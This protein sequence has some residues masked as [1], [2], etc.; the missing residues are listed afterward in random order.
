MRVILTS[1]ALVALLSPAQAKWFGDKDPRLDPSALVTDSERDFYSAIVRVFCP[2]SK[3]GLPS[4]TYYST[5]FHVGAFDIVVTNAHAFSESKPNAKTGKSEL[6]KVPFDRCK[7]EVL[8][9]KGY[10]LEEVAIQSV[11]SRWD[12]PD[13][14]SDRSND[15]AIIKLQHETKYPK[16]ALPYR[17][18]FDQG[19]PPIAA[20]E[21]IDVVVVG[22]P[23]EIDCCTLRKS[24]GFVE[25]APVK[26]PHREG[27]Y[28]DGEP[29]R[30]S[31]YFV[32]GNYA[33][34]KGASGSP[35]LSNGKVIGIHQGNFDGILP[36]GSK[37][38]VYNP[39]RNYNTA[40]LFDERFYRDIQAAKK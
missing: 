11:N 6:V 37:D 5:G 13:S 10:P 21:R 36:D 28:K 40:I 30:N 38:R 34:S 4:K 16:T 15:I 35:L 33:A 12:D 25:R 1:I 29:F 31:R 19:S 9:S 39:A 3:D 2:A 7:V 18:F 27:A 24:F 17:Y 23:Q 20:G 26:F 32:V 14:F 8:D 22:F